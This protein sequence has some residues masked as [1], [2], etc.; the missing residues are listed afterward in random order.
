MYHPLLEGQRFIHHQNIVHITVDMPAIANGSAAPNT[1]RHQ[2][3]MNAMELCLVCNNQLISRFMIYIY[4]IW[5]SMWCYFFSKINQVHHLPGF[6]T[7]G[8]ITW[9]CFTLMQ[10][11]I[12]DQLSSDF[13]SSATNVNISVLLHYE[14]IITSQLWAVSIMPN[15]GPVTHD[16]V[17]K[18]K[19]FPHY[20]PI[21]QGI[22]RSPVNSPHKGQWRGPLVFLWS[23]PWINGWVNIREAGDLR[24]H[25]AHYDVIVMSWRQ[26]PPRSGSL[27]NIHRT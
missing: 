3:I 21:V 15:D 5:P 20:W 17:I 6:Q 7:D 26:W 23:A 14:N 22:H 9:W 25:H 19:H 1:H 12:C 16:D 10:K 27:W 8:F 11:A 18:W 24:R 2:F 13:Q 4:S